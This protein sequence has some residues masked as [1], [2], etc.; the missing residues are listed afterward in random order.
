LA[1]KI[2]RVRFAHLTEVGLLRVDNVGDDLRRVRVEDRV[3]EEMN[4]PVASHSSA[5]PSSI[6]QTIYELSPR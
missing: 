4:K 5:N 6:C 2:E 1:I 3:K